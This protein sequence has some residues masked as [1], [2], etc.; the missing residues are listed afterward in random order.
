MKLPAQAA[1]R[2]RSA[3]LLG[4]G[5][6]PTGGKRAYTEE[7]ARLVLHH[8]PTTSVEQRSVDRPCMDS[9]FVWHAP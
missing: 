2:T 7:E 1:K 9:G 5:H 4:D 6:S 8:S 3:N